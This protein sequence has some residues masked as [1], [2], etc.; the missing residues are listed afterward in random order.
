[1]IFFFGGRNWL[2]ASP[3]FGLSKPMGCCLFDSLENSGDT[4]DDSS[5]FDL[6]RLQEIIP[7]GP[8]NQLTNGGE[9]ILGRRIFSLQ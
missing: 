6:V 7:G 3:Y 1:M 4:A 2:L 8:N 5:I 9:I